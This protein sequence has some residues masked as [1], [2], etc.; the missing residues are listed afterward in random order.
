VPLLIAVGA[1]QALLVVSWVFGTGLPGRVGAVV[2]GLLASAASDAA[3]MHWHQDGYQPVL[4]VLGIAIPVMFVHQL[5][6]GV[7]RTRV[8][9]SLADISVLLLSVIAIAGLIVLRYQDNGDRT[10][11]AVT[12]ALTVGLL[13]AHLTD[14]VFPV[15]RF[16][17]MIDRGLPAV[18]LGVI[19]G[20]AVGSYVL[21][22]LIAYAGGRGAFGGAATAAVG[23]LLSIGASF[24]WV[25]STLLPYPRK[26]DGE[27][28]VG[29][30][31]D[32]DPDD[33][34]PVT[35]TAHDDDVLI[36]TGVPRLRPVAAA[37][38]TLSLSAPAGYVLMNAL[39]G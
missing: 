8:V 7:V 26:P 24:A 37:L 19:A 32:I 13:V 25:H 22:D 21:R 39:A 12:A 1:I 2:M 28:A 33:L 17:P 6:R 16:D 29:Q 10:A 38:L 14:S 11:V 36:W 18:V 9:E 3:V 35:S 34:P 15:V 23:C 31:E 30:P 27:T 20:G 5:T 4:A